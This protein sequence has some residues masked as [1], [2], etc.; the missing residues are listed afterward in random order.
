MCLPS[1]E[2]LCIFDI[3]FLLSSRLL[4]CLL[5]LTRWPRSPNFPIFNTGPSPPQ[6]LLLHRSWMLC[7]SFC[8]HVLFALFLNFSAL[9]CPHPV[10]WTLRDNIPPE[11]NALLFSSRGFKSL[12]CYIIL[13]HWLSGHHILVIICS[14]MPPKLHVISARLSQSAFMQCWRSWRMPIY[15]FHIWRP[16]P[17]YKPPSAAQLAN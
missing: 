9:P 2:D 8:W 10:L 15:L 5:F 3:K 12:H 6:L 17:L 7:G 4:S 14:L 1:L 11:K 16:C 13:G